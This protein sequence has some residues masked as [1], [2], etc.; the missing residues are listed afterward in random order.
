MS[1][2]LNLNL[3]LDEPIDDE[4]TASKK[5]EAA[6]NLRSH[7]NNWN[8]PIEQPVQQPQQTQQRLNSFMN[9]TAIPVSNKPKKLMRNIDA[10]NFTEKELNIKVFGIGGAGNNMVNHMANYSN[11]TKDWLYAIN[12]DYKVLRNMPEDINAILIGNRITNGHGSGS[13]PE[14]GMKAALEDEATIREALEGTDVLFIVSG[15]GKGTGT[16]A[17][18]VVAKIA[19]E[20]GILTLS[21]VNLP[22]I[23]NEGPEIYKKGQLGL[24]NL[25]AETNGILTISNE[26]LFTETSGNITL[27]DAFNYADSVI[28]KVIYEIITLITCAS[29]INVDFNDVKTFFREPTTFQV[30]TFEFENMENIEGAILRQL[31]DQIYQDDIKNARQVIIN[32][33]LNPSVS[34]DFITK[35]AD[36]LTN[37]S[38]NNDLNITYAVDYFDNVEFA[39]ASA[40]IAKEKSCDAELMPDSPQA[41]SR[42]TAVKEVEP[43]MQKPVAPQQPVNLAQTAIHH[44]TQ[45]I[46][47]NAIPQPIQTLEVINTKT[48][49]LEARTQTLQ[50]PSHDQVENQKREEKIRSMKG[51]FSDYSE[52][53]NDIDY[54]K[55]SVKTSAEATKKEEDTQSVRRSFIPTKKLDAVE[56]PRTVTFSHPSADIDRQRS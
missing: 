35:V 3:F 18:P 27:K 11:I 25:A 19:K 42:P 22:S 12:T 14:I 24:R 9:Q 53:N 30:N 55:D 23:T 46:I 29:V 40:I 52:L 10:F 36:A 39:I 28:S 8:Q 50:I 44:P 41:Y 32:Y 51:I 26:K 54:F 4:A 43:V 34:R 2:K 7:F 13:D 1:D 37:I 20:M 6:Q 33:K 5:E 47:N 49:E 17:S 21:I 38:A 45:E 15:M 56:H 31:E 48:E 16:G